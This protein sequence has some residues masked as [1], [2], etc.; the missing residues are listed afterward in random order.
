LLLRLA[1]GLALSPVTGGQYKIRVT[2]SCLI[3]RLPLK[4]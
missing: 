2:L 1:N 4:P 3:E